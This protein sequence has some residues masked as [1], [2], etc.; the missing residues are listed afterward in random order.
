MFSSDFWELSVSAHGRNLLYAVS[1]EYTQK[2]HELLRS[3]YG[4][5][6]G[7]QRLA[8]LMNLLGIVNKLPHLLHEVMFRIGFFYEQRGPEEVFPKVFNSIMDKYV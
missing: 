2:L 5:F 1:V 7:A 3:K 4:I 8:T 6:A